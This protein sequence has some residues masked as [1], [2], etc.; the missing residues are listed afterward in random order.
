MT[1]TIPRKLGAGRL[2]TVF[3]PSETAAGPPGDTLPRP[4][5]AS[6]GTRPDPR[7][8]IEAALARGERAVFNLVRGLRD[9]RARRQAVRELRMMGRSRLDDLG[10]KPDRIGHVVNAMLAARRGRAAA[11]GGTTRQR[12]E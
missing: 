2:L 3:T 11:Q 6:P 9:G 1:A 8:N 7:R 10:I 5:S 12:S 4:D